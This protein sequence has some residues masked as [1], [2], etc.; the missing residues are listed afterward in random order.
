VHAALFDTGRPVLVVPQGSAPET[1]GQ[2]VVVAWRDDSRTL[3]AVLGALRWLSGASETHVIAGTRRWESTPEL[4]AIFAEHDVDAQ[5]HVL[6]MAGQRGFGEALLARAH[7]LG[8]DVIVLGAFAHPMLFGPLLGS[9]TKHMLA[10]AD[11]PVLM[12]Y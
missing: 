1:F 3:N 6:P 4:P 11:M 5:L 9:V 8:A 2:N 12:R 7:E 10:N